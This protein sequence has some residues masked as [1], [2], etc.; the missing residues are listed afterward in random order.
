MSEIKRMNQ[1]ENIRATVQGKIQQ[2]LEQTSR[3]RMSFED[4]DLLF[5]EIG[6][7]SLDLAQ[8]VV[9]LEQQLGVDPFRKSGT[10]IRTFGDLVRAYQSEL[11]KGP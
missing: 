1:S 10:A 7:D 11:E 9:A 2:V 5:V 6:L 3:P 4:D 8:V